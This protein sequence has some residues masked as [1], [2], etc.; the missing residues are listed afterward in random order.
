MSMQPMEPVEV[1]AKAARVAK[2]TFP[3]GSWAIRLRDE[4]GALF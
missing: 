2:A 3:K 1:P 4:L